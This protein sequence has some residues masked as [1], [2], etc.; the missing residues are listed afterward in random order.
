M[1]GCLLFV[2]EGAGRRHPS[3]SS[4]AARRALRRPLREA[5]G[6]RG[7]G[8][9]VREGPSRRK[10]EMETDEEEQVAR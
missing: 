4:S 5:Q 8:P 7:A 6:Q 2:L 3:R 9:S 1:G 10:C